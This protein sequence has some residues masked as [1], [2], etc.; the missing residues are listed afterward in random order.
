MNQPSLSN[1]R[2]RLMRLAVAAAVVLAFALAWLPSSTRFI[3]TDES[4]TW[5]VVQGSTSEMLI[6]VG[7][8]G[9]AP[10]HFLVMQGWTRV[11]GD[12]VIAM[13]TASMLAC[14]AAAFMWYFTIVAALEFV[15]QSCRTCYRKSMAT[16]PGPLGTHLSAAVGALACVLH[17]LQVT[18][19]STAR[20]YSLGGFI[21]ALSTWLL[22]Q[23]LSCPQ[24]RLPWVAYGVAAAAFCYTHHFAF[25][26]LVAHA[27]FVS[28]SA[29][30]RYKSGDVLHAK[31]L[32]AGFSLATLLAIVLFSP[33]SPVLYFQTTEVMRDFW[34]PEQTPAAIISAMG[35]WL[36]GF[37][38]MPLGI[39]VG[40]IAAFMIIACLAVHRGGAAGWLFLLTAVVPWLACLAVS[41]VAGRPLLQLR[42]LGFAQFGWFG[43]LAVFLA[44]SPRIRSRVVVVLLAACIAAGAANFGELF[45][46]RTHAAFAAVEFLKTEY[47]LGDLILVEYAADVNRMR[48]VASRVGLSGL[49]IQFPRIPFSARGH[50][51]HIASLSYDEILWK[52]S[53]I[54]ANLGPRVW[55]V[56]FDARGEPTLPITFDRTAEWPFHGGS[57]SQVKIVL[58]RNPATVD[59]P[60][61]R[62]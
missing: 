35:E 40:A 4:F 53:G 11:F 45:T 50:S 43:L 47:A 7:R 14:F 13:R 46:H 8:D 15:E 30:I 10:L 1:L 54:A 32:A 37:P 28:G 34:I 42:Y 22:L 55:T 41:T 57:K 51:V 26:T 20:M 56:T 60:G 36:T 62:F 12:S 18:S 21:N 39:A 33:W 19:G 48:Y 9:H 17:P 44:T 2:S 16:T 25:F 38:S 52:P 6:R 23:A 31:A 59:L 58:F 29:F 24:R 5:R 3:T 49:N 61:N 27:V